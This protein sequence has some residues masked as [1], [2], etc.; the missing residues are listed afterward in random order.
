MCGLGG[1]SLVEGSKINSRELANALL[2]EM[3]YRGKDASGFA[4]AMRDGQYGSYKNHVRGSQLELG[5]LPRRADSVIMHTRFATH[6]THMDNANNHPLPSVDKRITLTHNGVLFSHMDTRTLLTNGH[7]LPEVDS[8]VAAEMLS[9]YGTDGLGLIAGDAAF[10]WFDRETGNTLHLAKLN[11]SPVSIARLL[12]GSLVYASTDSILAKALKRMGLH[13]VGN[14]PK[15]FAEL[16]EGDYLQFTNGKSVQQEK[17]DWDYETKR[18]ATWRGATSGG[19]GNATTTSAVKS[20]IPTQKPVTAKS[21]SAGF[22]P[23]AATQLALPAR[24]NDTGTVPVTGGWQTSR[25]DA[26][27]A[28]DEAWMTDEPSGYYDE[29]DNWRSKDTQPEPVDEDA[30]QNVMMGGS[31]EDCFYVLD[32][33][34]D[35]TG[36]TTPQGLAAMLHWYAGLNAGVGLVAEGEALW[37]NHFADVGEVL[38][39]GALSSWIKH[40]EASQDFDSVVDGGFAFVRSGCSILSH[41]MA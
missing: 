37:V 4:F 21:A 17:L 1:F 36:Q 25:E 30:D 33:D 9:E 2:S 10:A 23:E 12:D 15:T 22:T 24:V 40:P 34:G 7:L 16:T 28:W 18:V 11:H 27:K 31:F 19:H 41:V 32:H 26:Q 5:K 3:E 29:N 35:Y 6:G 8:S 38:A 20:S 13:W 39:D 14:Y